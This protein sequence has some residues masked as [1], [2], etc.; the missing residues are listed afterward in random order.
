MSN[1]YLKVLHFDLES[2]D[3]VNFRGRG[4]GGMDFGLA[5]GFFSDWF[6]GGAALGAVFFG[7]GD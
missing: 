5:S 3:F 2:S 7:V 1:S 6:L 4:L